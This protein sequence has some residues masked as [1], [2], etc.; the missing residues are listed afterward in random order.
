MAV[1]DCDKKCSLNQFLKFF[2]ILALG[3]DIILLIFIAGSNRKGLQTMKCWFAFLVL[4]ME[5][6][7]KW[8]ANDFDIEFEYVLE[9]RLP[10]MLKL[11]HTIKFSF[12]YSGVTIVVKFYD[13]VSYNSIY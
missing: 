4:I 7:T 6:L 10:I 1:L 5:T 2:F 11:V 8:P 9:A 3:G 12:W 13:F